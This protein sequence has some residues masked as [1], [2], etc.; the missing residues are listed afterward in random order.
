MVNREWHLTVRHVHRKCNVC[1]DRM[2]VFGRVHD[3]ESMEYEE[4]PE[5]LLD[6]IEEEA[7]TFTGRPDCREVVALQLQLL[8]EFQSRG[9]VQL[10]PKVK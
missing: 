7:S 2:D 6:F 1:V 10:K 8:Q 3:L 9:A 4:P 5:E